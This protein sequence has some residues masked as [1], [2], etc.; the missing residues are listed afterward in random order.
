MTIGARHPC[1]PTLDALAVNVDLHDKRLTGRGDM[2]RVCARS[3]LR[4]FAGRF[5]RFLTL[6]RQPEWSNPRQRMSRSA[7]HAVPYLRRTFASARRT[8]VTDQPAPFRPA[9]RATSL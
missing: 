6:S 3:P 5:D 9:A 8:T 1:P 7:Y 2:Q 4:S